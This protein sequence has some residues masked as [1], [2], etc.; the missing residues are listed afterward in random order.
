VDALQQLT[1]SIA[2]QTEE[3][4]MSNQLCKNKI[5]RKREHDDEKKDRTKKI[6]KSII[7][8]LAN[9]AAA[10]SALED[11]LELTEGC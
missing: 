2:R 8:M 5:E 11:D 6:H 4:L 3:A 9:A 7:C 10:A 1:T